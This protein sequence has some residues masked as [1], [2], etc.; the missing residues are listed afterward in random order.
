MKNINISLGDF[1]NE[2]M[3]TR[4]NWIP[5]EDGKPDIDKN[6]MVTI[7]RRSRNDVRVV[8]VGSYNY[9]PFNKKYLWTHEDRMI[10]YAELP[11]PYRD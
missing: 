9:N 1:I 4:V 2:N 7:G 5:V 6:Y 10:A 11:E 8:T 3:E